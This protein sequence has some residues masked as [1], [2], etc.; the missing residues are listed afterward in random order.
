MKKESKYIVHIKTPEDVDKIKEIAASVQKVIILGG[1]CF[2][3][4]IAAFLKN[5]EVTVLVPTNKLLPDFDQDVLY[6]IEKYCREKGINI[7]FSENIL[8]FK[9]DKNDKLQTVITSKQELE[10]DLVIF[11]NNYV[12]N[13]RLAPEAGNDGSGSIYSKHKSS[14]VKIFDM[15]LAKTGLSEDEAQK[16]GFDYEAAIV[17]GFDKA[18]YYPGAEKI[19]IKMLANKKTHQII[20]AQIFGTGEVLK[21]IDVVSLAILANMTTEQLAQTDLCYAPPYSSAIDV[22]LTCANVLTNKLTG[23]SNGILPDEFKKKMNNNTEDFVLIDVRP[24][25][26]FASGHI[27]GSINI[28]LG[29][30]NN[31]LSELNRQKEIIVNCN[32]GKTSYM[33]HRKLKNNGFV[34]VKYIDGGVTAW[35]GELE[36]I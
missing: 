1:T 28:P 12:P 21:R 5:L 7:Y 23:I 10:T 36:R 15:T 13:S 27:K 2:A 26:L 19:I 3:L 8:D 30:L 17:P 29:Q 14:I 25:G 18:H 20:G 9:L 35:P 11:A 22:L 31:R 34:N 6:H 33:A 24:P 16:E 4:E 32:I